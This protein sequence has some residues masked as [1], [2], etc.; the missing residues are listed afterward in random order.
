MKT[1]DICSFYFPAD[2]QKQFEQFHKDVQLAYSIPVSKSTL[3]CKAIK[4]LIERGI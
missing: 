2:L 4:E 3:I 1:K